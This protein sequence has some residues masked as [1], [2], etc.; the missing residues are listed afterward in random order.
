MG[1]ATCWEL[2]RRGIRVLGL[3]QYSIP[4][5]QGSSHGYSRMTRMAYYEHPSYVPLIRRAHELWS[6]IEASS[7]EKIFHKV[8]GLYMGRPDAPLIQ[9]SLDSARRH[10]LQHELLNRQDLA[11]RHGQFTVPDDWVGFVEA[12]AGFLLPELAICAFV[13]AALE[14]GAI[15]RAQEQVVSW[16]E[17]ASGVSVTTS[18]GNYSADRLVFTSGVWCSKLLP[19]VNLRLSITRQVV[20]WVWPHEPAKFK[21]GALP[22]WLIDREDGSVYYGFPM[23]TVSPG[24]KIAVHA[25][26]TPTDPD[27]VT[28]EVTT[29]DEET[30]RVC[31]QRYLPSADGSLLAM[32]TCLYGNSPDGDFI[33]DRLPGSSRV[34]FAAGFSGHGFKFSSAIGEVLAELATTGNSR[35]P[36]DFLRLSRFSQ[37]RPH[38][39]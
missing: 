14:L 25:P 1:S 16:E 27:R 11:N 30:F 35:V 28:R 39:T 31:L 10:G 32:R 26:L 8:G 20:G 15:I 38:R 18:K 34:V 4:H 5:D 37:H 33:I 3:E 22:V 29:G 24:L 2:A 23:I 12:E 17:N 9:G 36:V 13:R 21:L 6:E 19:P 7:G